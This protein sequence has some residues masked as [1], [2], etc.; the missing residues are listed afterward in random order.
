MNKKRFLVLSILAAGIVLVGANGHTSLLDP[1]SGPT[2]L[3]E[4]STVPFQLADSSY[5]Y[6][7]FDFGWPYYFGYGYHRGHDLN[8][9]AI[10]TD[11]RIGT[12][13]AGTGTNALMAIGPL[14][15]A[16][17]TDHVIT[18]ILIVRKDIRHRPL[19]RT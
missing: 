7:G 12:S 1:G 2:N 5:F 16:I 15:H 3:S 4:L 9:G 11:T 10:M 6:F 8:T 14:P 18:V 19:H 17:G 13:T